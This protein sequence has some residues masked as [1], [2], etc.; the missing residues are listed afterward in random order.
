MYSVGGGQSWEEGWEAAEEV[1]K[2]RDI[3][4]VRKKSCE[5][6]RSRGSFSALCSSFR[7]LLEDSSRWLDG[8]KP[9]SGSSGYQVCGH[10]IG[11]H[12][13][14]PLSFIFFISMLWCNLFSWNAITETV[15]DVAKFFAGHSSQQV[16]SASQPQK[17]VCST[18][19]SWVSR[20]PRLHSSLESQSIMRHEARDCWLHQDNM[21]NVQMAVYA[22]TRTPTELKTMDAHQSWMKFTWEE[23]WIWPNLQRDP[24]WQSPDNKSTTNLDAFVGLGIYRQA[25][26]SQWLSRMF[27]TK[28]ANT[29]WHK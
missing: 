20:N 23:V 12:L 19:S 24:R 9:Y 21:E 15:F 1:H 5:V 25:T 11:Q 28:L 4:L 14:H 7:L 10:Y 29:S 8:G 27:P 18:F 3:L 2:S 17:L 26:R 6:K 13:R 22:F 16:C